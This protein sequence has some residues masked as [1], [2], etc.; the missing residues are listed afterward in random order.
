MSKKAKLKA[1]ALRRAQKV[2]RKDAQRRQYEAWKLSGQNTKS[3]RVKL[4][5]QRATPLRSADHSTGPCGNIG[6]K[7]CNPAPY[8][9]LSPRELASR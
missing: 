5:K 7:R 4:R 9:L 8:N 3:R 6:C 2:A 1:R